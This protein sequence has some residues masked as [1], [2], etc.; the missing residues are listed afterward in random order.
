MGGRRRRRI[1]LFGMD[2]AGRWSRIARC[3]GTAAADHAPGE[4]TVEHLVRTL[5][6][7]WE[8]CSGDCWRARRTGCRRGAIC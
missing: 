3:D 7:R 5:L 8:W 2:A 4:E 6:R 1:A